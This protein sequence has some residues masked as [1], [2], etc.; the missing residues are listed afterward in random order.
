MLKRD[1]FKP[2]VPKP[3]VPK[4]CNAKDNPR[5]GGHGRAVVLVAFVAGAAA[6]AVLQSVR[7]KRRSVANSKLCEATASELSPPVN[8]QHLVAC[9]RLP[10][11]VV[12][13]TAQLQHPSRQRRPHCGALDLPQY[14][15]EQTEFDTQY[16]RLA[17]KEAGVIFERKRYKA[18]VDVISLL[19]CFPQHCLQHNCT[20]LIWCYC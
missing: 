19:S 10:A 7:R 15:S 6:G 3:D 16:A 17:C 5:P 2:D 12:D 13:D 14:P 4:P 11:P 18:A 9:R 8:H 1:V 20:V